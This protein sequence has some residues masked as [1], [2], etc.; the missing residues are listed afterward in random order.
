MDAAPQIVSTRNLSMGGV[1]IATS[2]GIDALNGNPG[3]LALVT[4]SQVSIGARTRYS[5][6]SDFSKK[7]YKSRSAHSSKF[8]PNFK[9]QHIGFVL[10]LPSPN[11]SSKLVATVGYRNYYDWQRKEVRKTEWEYSGNDYIVNDSFI[12]KGLMDVFT[13]GFG[14]TITD[15]WSFG[16]L[17]HLPV[18]KGLESSYKTKNIYPE[19]IFTTHYEENWDVSAGGFFHL[20]SIFKLSDR[21]TIGVSCPLMH[22]FT[23]HYNR[24]YKE[25]WKMP[26]TLDIGIDY[27]LHP[28]LLLA[29]EI[30]N[31]PWEDY[32]IDNLPIADVK[33]GNVYRLGFEYGRLIQFRGGI[34]IDRLP[35][36]DVDE[37]GVNLKILAAGVGY[38]H[39]NWAIDSGLS[40]KFATFH[41]YRWNEEWDY[42]IR[43]LVVY[44]TIR[45]AIQKFQFFQSK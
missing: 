3:G 42:Q 37:H 2:R 19:E 10:P 32:R 1:Y 31:R 41:K 43:D 9:L 11:N 29:G 40:Y 8:V 5:G 7:F 12:S 4:T 21:L 13:L 26:G 14:A 45:L 20:G 39:G 15:K 6:K 25:K 38:Q 23:I 34:A 36:I 18:C 30:Q 17:L 44:S 33:S 35:L 16:I 28:N 22:R 27:R 24:E